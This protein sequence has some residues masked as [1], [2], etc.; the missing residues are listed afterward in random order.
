MLTKASLKKELRS[1]GLKTY[2]NKQG[3]SFVRKGDLKKIL[4]R[5]AEA[6]LS[7]EYTIDDTYFKDPEKAYDEL[8]ITEKDRDEWEID[9]E[10]IADYSSGSKETRIDPEDPAS[11]EIDKVFYIGG[12]DTK[13][14]I[15]DKMLK[16]D[17]Y[18]RM[19]ELMWE[20]LELDSGGYNDDFDL[21]DDRDGGDGPW[22][23]DDPY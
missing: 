6:Q 4:G 23:Y 22:D 9:V 12:G 17:A 13:V 10:M 16:D 3:E 15:T 2:R 18:E 20:G 21:E 11:L 1:L 5:I 14:E 7:Y 19:H 8:K